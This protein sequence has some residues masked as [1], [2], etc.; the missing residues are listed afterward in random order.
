MVR[1]MPW[2]EALG[3][4]EQAAWEDRLEAT[5]EGQSGEAVRWELSLDNGMASKLRRWDSDE[6]ISIDEDGRQVWRF[7][8]DGLSEPLAIELSLEGGKISM[9]FNPLTAA[10]DSLFYENR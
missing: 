7:D 3:A 5:Q 6:W 2:A 8:P 9:E 10:V 1:L 4:E